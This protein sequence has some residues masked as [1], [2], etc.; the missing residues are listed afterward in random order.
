LPEGL[1]HLLAVAVIGA[2]L[3]E[4]AALFVANLGAVVARAPEFQAALLAVVQSVA[5]ALGVEDAPNWE[6]VR[7]SIL[8]EINVQRVLRGA[9][10][11]V[12]MI[13][14]GLSFVLLNVAFILLERRS[15]AQ[16][17]D[18]MTSDPAGSARLR[19]VVADINARVGR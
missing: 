19:L 4:L 18:R 9:L 6:T 2:L 11:S 1:R 14:G 5:T 15:F 16:K 13:V 10:S 8:G 12:S 7:A 3:V 17:L